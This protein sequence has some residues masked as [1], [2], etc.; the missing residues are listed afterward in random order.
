MTPLSL[1]IIWFEV[2]ASARVDDF[3]SKLESLKGSTK[4]ASELKKLT[5]WMQKHQSETLTDSAKQKLVAILGESK[6]PEL[7]SC[8]LALPEGKL[9]TSKGKNRALKWYEGLGREG[10]GAQQKQ[11]GAIGKVLDLSEETIVTVEMEEDAEVM[12]MACPQLR[13][14]ALRR[15]FECYLNDERGVVKV[16]I[17]GDG[18]VDLVS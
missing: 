14:E 7:L 13:L 6:D 11:K 5:L 10:Q 16:A 3:A 18:D 9:T 4:Y 15:E 2:M 1:K 8:Y 12:E 17:T